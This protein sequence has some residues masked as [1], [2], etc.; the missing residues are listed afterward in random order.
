MIL[1]KKK[2]FFYY[3]NTHNVTFASK[4]NEYDYNDR[5]LHCKEDEHTKKVQPTFAYEGYECQIC[6]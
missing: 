1:Q 4:M 6:K 5:C 3:K 2:V